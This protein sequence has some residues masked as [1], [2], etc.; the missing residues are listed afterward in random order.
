M[1]RVSRSFPCN[2]AGEKVESVFDA[3]GVCWE[4]F[5]PDQTKPDDAA[6]DWQPDVVETRIVLFDNLAE[7][8]PDDIDIRTGFAAHGLKAKG[9]ESYASRQKLGKN[10]WDMLDETMGMIAQGEWRE[11]RGEGSVG[12]SSLVFEALVAVLRKEGAGPQLDDPET[13]PAILERAAASVKD[14]DA[15]K[16]ALK[17]PD[18]RAEYERIRSERAAAA[19][20]KA[21]EKALAARKEGGT[22]LAEEMGLIGPE[23]PTLHVPQPES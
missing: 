23:E 5:D 6:S 10:A 4:F 14:P 20:A 18:I 3:A 19:A 16:D 21:A 12:S 13:G 2:S 22:S 8:A 9:G 11:G 1:S 17:R 15:R 7:S